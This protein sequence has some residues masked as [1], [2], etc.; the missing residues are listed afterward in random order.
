[1]ESSDQDHD[2]QARKAADHV[3]GREGDACDEDEQRDD[4][5]KADERR[6]EED[7][8]EGRRDRSLLTSQ[9]NDQICSRGAVV[10]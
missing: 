8:A 2:G 6:T 9:P 5:R 3:G 7:R 4:L 1:M 10:A